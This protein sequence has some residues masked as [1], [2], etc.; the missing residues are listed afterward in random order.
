MKFCIYCLI[1]CK[2]PGEHHHFP[3]IKYD[4]HPGNLLEKELGG[5]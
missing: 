4:S 5:R 1:D 2:I 3:G